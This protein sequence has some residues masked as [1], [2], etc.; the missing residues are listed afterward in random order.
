[1]VGVQLHGITTAHYKSAGGATCDSSMQSLEIPMSETE[2]LGYS[3]MATAHA[4]LRAGG[5]QFIVLVAILK[6]CEV[7][8]NL[9]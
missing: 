4:M 5:W 1:M 9:Q 6:Y 2:W 7:I 3:L 8:N